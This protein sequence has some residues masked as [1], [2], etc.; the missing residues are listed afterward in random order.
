MLTLLQEYAVYIAIIDRAL[1]MGAAFFTSKRS[2][3][4][5]REK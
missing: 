5:R 3:F 2:Q 1:A 4:I